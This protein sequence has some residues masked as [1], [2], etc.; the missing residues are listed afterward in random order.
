MARHCKGSVGK[1]IYIYILDPN[2]QPLKYPLFILLGLMPALLCSQGF[3]ISGSVKDSEGK[4]LPYANVMLLR[5][6]DSTQ[7]KGVSA[8]ETGMF[9]LQSVPADLYFLQARYF[10]YQSGLIPLEIKSSITIGAIV[11]EPGSD[12]LDEVVVT[13]QVPTVER[14][15]DRIVFQVENPEATLVDW[16]EHAALIGDVDGLEDTPGTS[17]AIPPG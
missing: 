12:W 4:L 1:I 7:I 9:R 2:L 13:G 5:V 15:A 10:G 11:L 14:L 8:D 16:L 3:E 17:S 6:A